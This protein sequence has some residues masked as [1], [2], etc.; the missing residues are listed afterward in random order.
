MLFGKFCVGEEV[1]G[2]EIWLGVLVVWLWL[3]LLVVEGLV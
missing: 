1:V 2:E 3:L